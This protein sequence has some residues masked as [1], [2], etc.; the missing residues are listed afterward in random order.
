M[1]KKGRWNLETLGKKPRGSWKRTNSGKKASRTQEIEE[2][3]DGG[4]GK[5]RPQ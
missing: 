3:R 2:L 5:S 4:V 1:V